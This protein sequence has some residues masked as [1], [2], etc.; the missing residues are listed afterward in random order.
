V[1]VW[2]NRFGGKDANDALRAALEA[3]R[4]GRVA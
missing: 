2:R 1:K 4:E 3:E